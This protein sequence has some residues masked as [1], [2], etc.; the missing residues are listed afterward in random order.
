[1]LEHLYYSQIEEYSKK[2]KLGD[3]PKGASQLVDIFGQLFVKT[4]G[5]Q[6]LQEVAKLNFK[7]IDKIK[8][9]LNKLL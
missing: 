9:P 6:A 7:N 4:Y 2:Y 5:F 3:I 1:M 8:N